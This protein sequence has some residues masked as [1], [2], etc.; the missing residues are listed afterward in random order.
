MIDALRQDLRFAARTLRARPGFTAI[1]VLSMALGIGIAVI[2]FAIVDAFLLRPLPVSDPSRLAALTM[3]RPGEK[4]D[5]LSYLDYRDLRREASSFAALGAF[6]GG[7]SLTLDCAGGPERIGIDAVSANL[8]PLLGFRPL[9]GRGFRE[10]EDAP[11]GPPVVILGYDLWRSRFG[12]DRRLLGRTVLA[13]G[14]PHTVIGVMPPGFDFPDARSAWVPLGS[15]WARDPRHRRFLLVVGRLRA[16]T[17]FARARS[18]VRALFD[19]LAVLHPATNAGWS[20]GVEPVRD[21]YVSADLKSLLALLAGAAAVVLAIACSNVANLLLAQA[22]ERRREIALRAALG[23]TRGRIV[24]QLLT[25]N[26]A[27]AGAGGALGLFVALAGIAAAARGV[28]GQF[29]AWLELRFD[30][31]AA[32]FTLAVSVASGLLL[33]IGP[34]LQAVRIDLREPLLEGSRGTVGRAAARLRAALV[35]AEVALALVL[36]IGTSLL[37]RS[38]LEL[39]GADMGYDPVHLVTAWTTL[40]GDAYAGTRARGLRAIDLAR[41]I[42]AIPGLE[43]AAAGPPPIIDG[44][45]LETRAAVEGRRYRPGREPAVTA[46]G[47]TEHYFRTLGMPLRRGREPS[48]A[49]WSSRSGLAVVNEALVRALFPTGADA[50]GRTLL[51]RDLDQPDRLTIV[52]VVG[53]VRSDPWREAPPTVYLP[54]V[55]EQIHSIGLT[56]RTRLD[57]ASVVRRLR[58]AVRAADPGLPLYQ[59]STLGEMQ[60]SQ[61]TVERLVGQAFALF[62]GIALFLAAVGVYGVLSHTVSQRLREIGVRIALGAR[63]RDLLGLILGRGMLLASAGVA[64]GLVEALAVTRLFTGW[65]YGVSPRDPATF[66]AIAALLVGVSLIACWV[67]AARAMDVDPR[68]AIRRD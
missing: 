54:P 35:V 50:L 29:P 65:L 37:V 60:D 67:P 30:G 41:R 28:S 58:A 7:G 10:S 59:P 9:L 68:E 62:G 34:A 6:R 52:G 44:G 55:Y 24:R 51:L 14:R 63:R 56:V 8:F 40:Q 57:P 31:R 25:E 42:E 43:S 26:V 64:L 15:R 18:E 49:E 27:L 33:G 36:L 4:E 47:V 19:R 17:S 61:L 38:F 16:E 13:N 22:S 66:A 20:A 5:R 3:S 39:R 46:M 2:V 11:D 32:L 21:L 12:G 45:G 23:A 1:A 53:D 48:A